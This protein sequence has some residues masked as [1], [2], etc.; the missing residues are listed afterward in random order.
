MKLVFVRQETQDFKFST[1]KRI[2]RQAPGGGTS[3]FI[4]KSITHKR[5]GGKSRVKKGNDID[6]SDI[7]ESQLSSGQFGS[8]GSLNER[9]NTSSISKKTATHMPENAHRLK[10]PIKVTS[11]KSQVQSIRRVQSPNMPTAKH[12]PTSTRVLGSLTSQKTLNASVFHKQTASKY[13]Q[14]IEQHRRQVSVNASPIGEKLFF[15]PISPMSEPLHAHDNRIRARA[16]DDHLVNEKAI[17]RRAE[18]KQRLKGTVNLTHKRLAKS[19]GNGLASYIQENLHGG[20]KTG[21]S[22]GFALFDKTRSGKF[23]T[24][25]KAMR[26]TTHARQKSTS[27]CFPMFRINDN[28]FTLPS[29]IKC[30]RGES[31]ESCRR[32]AQDL[33]KSSHHVVG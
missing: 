24:Y 23:L 11:D 26:Q 16:D 13:L 30:L 3:A 32:S 20:G 4:K 7:K 17:Q 29:P 28:V 31:I 5:E 19:Y 6:Q 12:Q 21:E 10:S 27:N 14:T 25:S 18:L 8:N 33:A 9:K 1:D 15:N 22:V 2:N